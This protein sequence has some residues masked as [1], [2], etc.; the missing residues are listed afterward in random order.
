MQQLEMMC[1][2]VLGIG[3]NPNPN[4]N[5]NPPTHRL[6][7]AGYSASQLLISVRNR[8]EL[9]FS[10]IDE[11]LLISVPRV[12][13]FLE[14]IVRPGSMA[15]VR[16]WTEEQKVRVAGILN[17]LF[18]SVFISAVE[19]YVDGYEQTFVM[20]YAAK[21]VLERMFYSIADLKC[22]LGPRSDLFAA[23]LRFIRYNPEDPGDLIDPR[24][25]YPLWYCFKRSLSTNKPNAWRN[26]VNLTSR[27]FA[28]GEVQGVKQYFI[29]K[30]SRLVED[31][32]AESE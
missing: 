21:C 3:R 10:N 25:M 9:D 27:D 4:P 30:A 13:T 32:F 24:L 7:I 16:R 12:Q 18:S 17:R 11:I 14:S 8:L 1:D 28:P 26:F 23:H 20:F 31:G 5:L 6:V 19:R 22:D 29:Q 15:N 2:R